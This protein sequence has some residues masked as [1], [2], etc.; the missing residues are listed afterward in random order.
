LVYKGNGHKLSELLGKGLR[1]FYVYVQ[2]FTSYFCDIIYSAFFL[3]N[4]G[5]TNVLT[6]KIGGLKL[7]KHTI[8]SMQDFE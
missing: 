6:N 5:D 3:L 2:R 8:V 4:T 1:I 7:K